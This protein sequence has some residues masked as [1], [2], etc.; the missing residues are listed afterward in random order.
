MNIYIFAVLYIMI[1]MLR[2]R[3]PRPSK[4]IITLKQW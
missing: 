3:R 1:E 4:Y 2:V